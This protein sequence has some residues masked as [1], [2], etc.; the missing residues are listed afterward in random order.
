M[1][2]D[3][4]EGCETVKHCEGSLREC[5]MRRRKRKLKYLSGMHW[6]GEKPLKFIGLSTFCRSECV[7][8][9]LLNIVVIEKKHIV[10][11]TNLSKVVSH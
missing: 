9:F 2:N 6:R 11:I 7:D 4:S 3:P 1:V 5:I 8:P 10:Y